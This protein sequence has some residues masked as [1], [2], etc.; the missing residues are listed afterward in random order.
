MRILLVDKS[1]ESVETTSALLKQDGHD[2]HVVACGIEAV[3]TLN[4]LYFDLA[5]MDVEPDTIAATRTIRSADASIASIPIIAMVSN[6][7]HTAATH[8]MEAGMNDSIPKP[9]SLK[10]FEQTLRRVHNQRIFQT[11]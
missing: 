7:P 6:H 1:V 8:C 3:N 9:F 10:T 2:V 11:R 4:S 5:L